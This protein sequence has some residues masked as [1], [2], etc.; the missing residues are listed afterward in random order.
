MFTFTL[1]LDLETVYSGERIPIFWEKQTAPIL[2]DISTLQKDVPIKRRYPPRQCH[3]P[4]TTV[5]NFT[6]VK[7]SNYGYVVIRSSTEFSF[8]ETGVIG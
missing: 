4:G 2:R 6:A 7:Y 5:S 3:K 8:K 1:Y